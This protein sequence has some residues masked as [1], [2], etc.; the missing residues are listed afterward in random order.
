MADEPS[1]TEKLFRRVYGMLEDEVLDC[2]R[3]V[4]PAPDNFDAYSLQFYRLHLDICRQIDSFFK[5][6]LRIYELWPEGEDEAKYGDYCPIVEKC[7]LREETVYLLVRDLKLCPFREWEKNKS[8]SWWSD[9]NKLKHDMEEHFKKAN[10][11][12]V[13]ESL[14]AFYVLLNYDKGTGLLGPMATKAF[15]PKW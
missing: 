8:P 6:L 2:Y 11:M 7:D 1:E 5:Y 9:H 10:L 4:E 14:A 3:Y 13:W 15:L 12:I